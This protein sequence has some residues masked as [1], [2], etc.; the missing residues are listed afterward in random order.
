[1]STGT[2]G[3]QDVG[4]D[5]VVR[6]RDGGAAAAFRGRVRHKLMNSLIILHDKKPY[7]VAVSA[8][9]GSTRPGVLPSHCS[10]ADSRGSGERSR[11]QGCTANRASLFNLAK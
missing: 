2:A 8:D 1:V 3:R 7:T 11:R 10:A 9:V 5:V 4:A 6:A